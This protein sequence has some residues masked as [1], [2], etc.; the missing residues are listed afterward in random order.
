MSVTGIGSTYTYVYNC[1]TNKLSSKNGED[2][3]FVNYFN[4]TAT[5]DDLKKLNGYNYAMKG[6]IRTMIEEFSNDFRNNGVFLMMCMNMSF[7]LI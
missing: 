6:D 5:E 1:E 7:L 2:D 3:A 4:G